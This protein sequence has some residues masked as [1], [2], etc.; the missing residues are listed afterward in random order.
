ME[1]GDDSGYSVVEDKGGGL[2]AGNKRGSVGNFGDI[3]FYSRRDISDI[4]RRTGLAVERVIHNR[5]ERDGDHAKIISAFWEVV[6]QK[7]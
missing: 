4:A 3:C 7:A 6:F 5:M 1:R 2:L